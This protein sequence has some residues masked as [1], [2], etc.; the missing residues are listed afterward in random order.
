[1]V[2]RKKRRKEE[3]EEKKQKCAIRKTLRWHSVASTINEKNVKCE[4]RSK[5]KKG[6]RKWPESGASKWGINLLCIN[7]WTI[8]T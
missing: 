7:L 6:G 3:K 8:S 1:M 2:T 5:K 4:E